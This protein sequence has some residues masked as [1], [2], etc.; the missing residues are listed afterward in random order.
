[1]SIG[2]MSNPLSKIRRIRGVSEIIT[3]GGQALHAY[4]EQ[5]RGGD[6]I[7][8][9]EEFIR[10]IDAAQ[11]GA[12]PI[13]AETLW[14][15][16]YKNGETHFFPTFANPSESVVAFQKTFG[17]DAADRF[18]DA[19]EKIADG[20]IDLLGLKNLYVGSEIDW[21]REPLSSMRSPLKHWTQF[22]DLD[23]RETG[24]KKIVWEL[25][26]Q[27]HFFTLG[28]AYWLTGDERFANIFAL[29]IESWMDD[30]PPG[31]GINWSSSLEV[32][33]R[34][35]SWIWAFHFFRD[36]EAFTPTLFKSALKY[37]YRHGRHIERYLSTYYSPNTHLT[38][39][40]IGLYYLGT[41]LPF[42]KQSRAWRKLGE[43]IL[44]NEISK[45][46]LP[47]GVYFE[48]SMWYQRYTL[49]F[50]VHFVVLRSL[51]GNPPYT[52]AA[53]LLEKR[54]ES[55]FDFLMNM[56]LPDGST[57]MIG[58]DDGGRMLP[59][60]CAP[61]DDFRGTLAL[62]AFLYG[63]GDQ[64]HISGDVSQEVFW[65]MGTGGVATYDRMKTVEP[66][67]FSTNFPDGG[68]CVLRDG[69]L[70]TDNCMIVDCGEVGS[71]TGGHGHADALAIELAI[72]G[73]TVLVDSG[74]YTYHE[75]REMRDYF[76]S[77]T[78]HNSLSVDGRSSSEPGS[79]FAWKTRANATRKTWIS[80]ER[81]D[82][83]EG[84]HDGFERLE[85]PV[86]HS[87]SILFLKNDYWIMR[88]LS[89]TNGDHEYAL[90]FHF[91]AE[92]KPAIS[93]EGKCVG[94]DGW[95]MWGFGDNGSWEQ[96]ESWISV[97]HGN[98][99]NASFFRFISSGS[100]TQE[101]WTFILPSDRGRERPNV[102]EIPLTSGR[103][104]VI[105]YGGY[106]DLFVYND[107]PDVVIANGI[108]DSNFRYSWA[109]LSAGESVPDE[110]VLIDGDCLRING[111]DIFEPH[112]LNYASACRFGR[113][114]YVRTDL[115]RSIKT[116]P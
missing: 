108:F 107:E 109:R 5:R 99:T 55:A 86:T 53:A 68:Y 34:T 31:L 92:E 54:L 115:G 63:R 62:G 18:I 30:N 14:Q 6:G 49:D 33:L 40:A 19:A 74:T 113:E 100:G 36:S 116:L 84:M 66:S 75:S 79:M 12:A 114:L 23:S 22:D 47:D 105:K 57:P 97:N 3:R 16:F 48:Q 58:D 50:Y 85:S 28:V 91:A 32:S 65:L 9:D 106:T 25:N 45:Q 43:D 37:L 41:Q 110:F 78:A 98:M 51:Q 81:F 39:E 42:F 94:T 88:D 38:G 112:E 10:L 95:V 82:L 44:F 83:F 35:I 70:D 7:P 56:T 71:L 80:K 1:M 59:L 21:H 17:D 8:T 26:R 13:I 103:A 29:H 96:K 46:I 102:S 27:Q 90:N 24:N 61:P 111:V 60:T 2:L 15:R 93:G 20:R 104:F 72:R 4:G 76:R 77:G 89:E 67:G 69:P 11:F 87:R 73:K 52:A 64:K 101:F